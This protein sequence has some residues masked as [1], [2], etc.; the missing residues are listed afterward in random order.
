L[1]VNGAGVV[2]VLLAD[3][4]TS[5]GYPRIATVISADVDR[6]AQ[7]RTGTAFR[8]QT[9]SVAEAIAAARAKAAAEATWLAA[10]ATPPLAF[11]DRLFAA[12]LIDGVINART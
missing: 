8:F 9:I 1:Q 4:Q 6:L 7:L 3:H 12:N 10:V 2:T 5:G 11:A